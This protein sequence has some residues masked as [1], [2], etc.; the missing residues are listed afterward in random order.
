MVQ[1]IKRDGT[2]VPF[3]KEK[4]IT[5]INSA[6]IE[7]DGKLYETDTAVDIANEIYQ[8]AVSADAPLTVE[9]IQDMVEDYLMRSERRD[10]AKAYIRFR[11]RKEVA[12]N[13]SND[14][15]AA[16]REKLNADDPQ[17][18][19]ANMD[20]SSFGGRT[21]EASSVVTKK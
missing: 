13:Y 16:I 21:G 17:N 18:Q 10:V 12:R 19:N 3:Y 15:I 14:F 8:F 1:I 7:V 2:L 20:E 4:I 5:A 11:Y 6:L 9:R